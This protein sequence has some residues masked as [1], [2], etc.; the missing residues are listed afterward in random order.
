M[1]TEDAGRDVMGC[2]TS[3][4]DLGG[5]YYKGELVVGTGGGGHGYYDNS[6]HNINV[7]AIGF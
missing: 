1:L 7:L 2:W 4:K 3:K 5:N 6:S